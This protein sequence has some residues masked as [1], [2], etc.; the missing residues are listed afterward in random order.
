[1][2]Y[3]SSIAAGASLSASLAAL[4]SMSLLLIARFHAAALPLPVNAP[5][6]IRGH[7]ALHDA[8][9]KFVGKTAA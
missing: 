6:P 5:I 2:L 4:N 9:L 3:A 1:L 8:A 7:F